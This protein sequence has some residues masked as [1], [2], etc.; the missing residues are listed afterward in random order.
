MIGWW[1]KTADPHID[2]ED[3]ASWGHYLAEYLAN[4]GELKAIDA[5][6][7]D[8]RKRPIS[9][10]M[11]VIDGLGGRQSYAIDQNPK[12]DKTV[13]AAKERLLVA[14]LDDID[15]RAGESGSRNGKSYA[16][17]RVADIAGHTLNN[18]YPEKYVFD[19]GAPH[20]TRDRQLVVMKNVWRSANN[21]PLLPVPDVRKALA[22]PADK[23]R[24]ILDRYLEAS[25]DRR[26]AVADEIEKLGLGALPGV[27]QRRDKAAEKT[28]RVAWDDLAKRL[29]CIVADIEISDRAANLDAAVV[30]RLEGMKGK[31]FDAKTFIAAVGATLKEAPNDARGIR[32][33]AAR[34]GDDTGFTLKFEVL[35]RPGN[36]KGAPSQ[37][38]FS[39]SIRVGT[40][41]VRGQFGASS[42]VARWTNGD[43]PD[44]EK[45]LQRAAASEFDQ[46][47][48]I[49]IH[50]APEWRKQ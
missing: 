7:H 28:A 36:V 15:E 6:A 45:V 41:F 43:Y 32:V 26:R 44:L 16:D 37:W 3:P 39:E 24:P 48:E 30:K 19:L 49:R 17:P 18:L 35:A 23:L 1:K 5:L 14:A 29:A 4:C 9:V 40:E 11:S 2:D 12:K 46:P 50:I 10:R 8:L 25:G 34:A 42:V 47:I 20:R 22:I 21:E 38:G 33:F 31:S 13:E 27:L